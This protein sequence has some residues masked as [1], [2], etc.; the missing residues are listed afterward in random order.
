MSNEKR[1]LLSRFAEE[2]NNSD[3]ID[4]ASVFTSEELDTPM[5][6]VRCRIIEAGADLIDML[7]ECF[8]LPLEEDEVSIF[9]ILVTVIDEMKEET[10]FLSDA[11]ARLNFFI[12]VGSFGIDD[13]ENGLV[14]KYAVPII[15][16]LS[17]E[18]KMTVMLTAFNQ[19]A[20]VVDKYEG[21]LMLVATGEMESKEMMDLVLNR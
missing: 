10:R 18:D 17:D 9:T 19:A 7:G 1:E 14:Y 11:A 15:N 20:G 21:Y 6:V 8:F 2:I 12:P 13:N 16:K 5:D 3:D 4:N